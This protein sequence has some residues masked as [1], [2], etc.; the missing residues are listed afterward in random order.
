MPRHGFGVGGGGPIHPAVEAARFHRTRF[1][2]GSAGGGCRW[3][4]GP[5]VGRRFLVFPCLAP[6]SKCLNPVPF[7]G[8][9][10]SALGLGLHRWLLHPRTLLPLLETPLLAFASDAWL[11]LPAPHSTTRKG[12]WQIHLTSQKTAGFVF[13]LQRQPCQKSFVVVIAA[14]PRRREGEVA[15]LGLRPGISCSFAAG[16]NGSH[17]PP[18]A[19]PAWCA[20]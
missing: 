10:V 19:A 12:C 4:S 1:L 6:A 2:L 8:P 11:S 13:S 15:A 20:A 18:L 16:Q 3:D 14:N 17:P 7:A 5:T 9:A